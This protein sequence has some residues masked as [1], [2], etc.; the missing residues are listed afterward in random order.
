MNTPRYGFRWSFL[1]S[2]VFLAFAAA[3]PNAA[4]GVPVTFAFEGTVS[5]VQAQQGAYGTPVVNWPAVGTTIAGTYT[6]DSSAPDAAAQANQGLYYSPAPG[7]PIDVAT[8]GF[9]WA[10][11]AVAVSVFDNPPGGAGD[12]YEAVDWIPSIQITSPPGLAAAFDQWNFSLL[13]QGDGTFLDSTAL[14]LTPPDLARA[15]VRRLTLTGD[16]GMNTSPVP[17]VTFI[18]TLDALTLV[19]EPTGPVAACAALALL[20]RRR[21]GPG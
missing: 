2:I 21:R 15:T 1:P 19:P 4:G 18:A 20:L 5:G 9:R 10:G 3:L 12:S 13:L 6:F 16:T 7:G 14:P 8:D 17:V 11:P